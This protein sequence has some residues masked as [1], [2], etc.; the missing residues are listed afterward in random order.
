MMNST[1]QN[2]RSNSDSRLNK[3]RRT[4]R[5]KFDGRKYSGR[6]G[7]SLASALLANGVHLVGRSFKYHRPRG[8][9][10]AGVEEPN[11]LIT[12]VGRNSTAKSASR[13]GRITPNLRATQVELYEGLEAFSQNRFPSLRYDFQAA[14]GWFGRF[15]VAGFYYKTFKGFG[16]GLGRVGASFAWAKIYEPLIRR[17][18]GL[19]KAPR[20]S[21]PDHYAQFNRHCDI[22]VIGGGVAG[23]AAALRAGKAGA[24]VILCDE[25]RQLGGSLLAVE[26][27]SVHIDNKYAEQWVA[28]I[29]AEIAKLKNVTILTRTQ[30]FG[31]FADGFAALS[32][33]T[34]DHISAH[35]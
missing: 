11:A 35:R 8:I 7:D 2:F 12:L 9:I 4:I 24:S 33:Q 1:K 19:G 22:L 32:Q 31:L 10:G 26:S 14:N 23:L 29:S 27:D 28:S 20:A 18:A 21:D 3:E 25:N 34:G 15:L 16:F 17:S 6:E 30:A 13:T 5:F